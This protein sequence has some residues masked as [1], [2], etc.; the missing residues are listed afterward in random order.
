MTDVVFIFEMFTCC[1]QASGT[2]L[3]FYIILMSHEA[4]WEFH[5]QG[6]CKHLNFILIWCLIQTITFIPPS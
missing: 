6:S 1:F 2:L 4:G 3:D 5:H